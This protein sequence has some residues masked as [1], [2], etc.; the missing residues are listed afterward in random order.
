MRQ[1]TS[2]EVSVTSPDSI[3]LPKL[4]GLSF[5]LAL[6]MAFKL[7]P[8]TPPLV[9]DASVLR[10]CLLLPDGGSDLVFCVVFASET[11]L[12]GLAGSSEGGGGG[13]GGGGC[14]GGGLGGAGGGGRSLAASA[15]ACMLLGTGGTG[16]GVEL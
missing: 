5:C 10:F 16:G 11:G 15:T 3:A 7:M 6:M 14:E 8:P 9:L 2:A 13:G 1:A 4:L 12:T